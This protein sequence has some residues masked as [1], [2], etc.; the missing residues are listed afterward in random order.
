MN[1]RTQTQIIILIIIGFI[2]IAG[3]IG[4]LLSE[5]GKNVAIPIMVDKFILKNDKQHKY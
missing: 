4:L 3:I 2:F 5:K 1:K